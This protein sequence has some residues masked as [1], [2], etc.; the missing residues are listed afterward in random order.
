MVTI[1]YRKGMVARK[2]A[3]MSK[4]EFATAHEKTT[5]RIGADEPAFVVEQLGATDWTKVPPVFLFVL[6]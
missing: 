3:R 2:F 5:M 6:L 4:I 1:V